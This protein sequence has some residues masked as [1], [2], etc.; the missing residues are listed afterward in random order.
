[1]CII[2]TSSMCTALKMNISM[3]VISKKKIIRLMKTTYISNFHLLLLTTVLTNHYCYAYYVLF[4]AIEPLFY[5]IL[6]R[7]GAQEGMYIHGFIK[8]PQHENVSQNSGAIRKI[9]MLCQFGHKMFGII[10]RFY[11]RP[12]YSDNFMFL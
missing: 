12:T 1:M 9:Y 6:Q 8:L 7:I 5:Y 3:E 10:I 11:G 2:A 4:T